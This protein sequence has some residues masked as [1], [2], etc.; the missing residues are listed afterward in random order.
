MSLTGFVDSVKT[1]FL[2]AA[3]NEENALPHVLSELLA[4]GQ[5]ALVVDDGSED[6]TKN[7]LSGFGDDIFTVRNPAN[8]GQGAA[9]QTAIACA[10]LL[11][12]DYVVTFDAD[13]QHRLS[14]ALAMIK[15]M[16]QHPE[17]EILIGSRFLGGT[18]AMPLIKRV[19]L[20]AGVFFTN[21]FSGL[22]ITDTHNGLRVLRRT[23]YE[24][25]SFRTT[26]MEH[27][28][29]I[30]DF[31]GTNRVKFEEFPVTIDYTEYSKSK[32]QNWMNAFRLAI[33]MLIEKL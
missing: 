29:E 12:P 22:D 7:V 5:K 6:G 9:L 24:R 2:I 13:G 32:G 8:L 15:H 17:L 25:F 33:K 14:D 16:D 1:L 31:L 11:K 28:S 10:R 19:T 26:G 3:F 4:N 23:F 30:L 27:A 18:T 21:H 20:K